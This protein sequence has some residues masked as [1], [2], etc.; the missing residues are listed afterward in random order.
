MEAADLL[1]GFVEEIARV[2]IGGD[3]NVGLAGDGRK[4]DVVRWGA[5][6]PFG[7]FFGGD[8]GAEGGVELHFA[9]D[10]K[11]DGWLRFG[12]GLRIRIAQR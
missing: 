11:V 10:E 12:E 1:E 7:G 3:E 6:G 4:I 5:G 2:E 9:V 8:G